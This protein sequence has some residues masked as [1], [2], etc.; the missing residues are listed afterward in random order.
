MKEYEEYIGW[1]DNKGDK[2]FYRISEEFEV[3]LENRKIDRMRD[4]E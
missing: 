1:I 2:H 3:R 4:F